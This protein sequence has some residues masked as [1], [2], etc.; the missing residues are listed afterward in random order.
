MFL[1]II[2]LI[3][4][5][6]I[7]QLSE[8]SFANIHTRFVLITKG[9][10]LFEIQRFI[11]FLNS[12]D[13]ISTGLIPGH[14]Q[15]ICQLNLLPRFSW[16]SK[17]G[18]P[19]PLVVPI[20]VRTWQDIRGWD[21]NIPCP[22][23]AAFPPVKQNNFLNKNFNTEVDCKPRKVFGIWRSRVT[24]VAEVVTR[25]ARIWSICDSVDAL[26]CS[27]VVRQARVLWVD[28]L[29]GQERGNR[30][31]LAALITGLALWKKM[32]SEVAW[33]LSYWWQVLWA[34]FL[35]YFAVELAN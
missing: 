13:E 20:P 32:L 8:T 16:A 29:A 19:G 24:R 11:C 35:L 10:D 28:V 34:L 14:S 7:V 25:V 23:V 3:L 1:F 21:C 6:Y 5:I 26:V 30:V 31:E 4:A 33:K 12:N 27:E 22:A 18:E 15:G 9:N 17:R 2:V